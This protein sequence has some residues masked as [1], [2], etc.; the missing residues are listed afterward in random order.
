MDVAVDR[1]SIGH[2][3]DAVVHDFAARREGGS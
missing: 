1:Q 3:T 2:R